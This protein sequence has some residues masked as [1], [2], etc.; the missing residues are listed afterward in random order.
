[1]HIQRSSS[2]QYATIPQFYDNYVH[3]GHAHFISVQLQTA[4]NIRH[5]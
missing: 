5:Y 1:M 2:I 4:V 3:N